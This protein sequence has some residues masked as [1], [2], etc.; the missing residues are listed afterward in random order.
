[1][2]I[3]D[4]E[5]IMYPLLQACSDGKEYRIDEIVPKLAEHFNLHQSELNELLPSGKQRKFRNRVTWA[6]SYLK[7]AG[8]LDSPR[9][10]YFAITERGLKVLN[11]SVKVVDND[12]LM[13]FDEFREFRERPKAD[14][15]ISPKITREE[16]PEEL[17]EKSFTELNNT[18][19]S[20][21]LQNIKSA[22]PRFFEQ[23]VIDLLVKM[24]YGGSRRDAGEALGKSH[25][26]GVDGIIKEDKLG[27]DVIYIQAKKWEN[28]VGRPDI[29][30]FA[31]SLEGMRANRGIF[32]TTSKYS[33]EALDYV[34]SIGKK[35]VL[36]DG[37]KLAQLMI[38][39]NV[40]VSPESVYEIKRVDTDYFVED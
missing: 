33:K 35:V 18:L 3:P 32:I 21:I 15:S 2:A 24:G 26:E 6:K 19:I 12:Y 31:G 22:S 10:G 40:G 5:S 14:S 34:N 30:R 13:Q 27:L 16:T 11:S 36:I 7:Q 39:H 20:E 38:E 37:E 28:T 17:I 4:Y 1:M 25:D 29:Q 9:R 8:L 23:L